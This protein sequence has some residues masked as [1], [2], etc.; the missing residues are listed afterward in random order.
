MTNTPLFS[1]LIANFNNGKFFKDCYDSIIAQSYQ[2]W[3]AIIVDDCST[4]NSVQLIRQL[5]GEDKRFKLYH[6][7]ENK[8]CGFTKRRCVELASGEICGFLDPDDIITENALEVT[9]S[10]HINNPETS[11]VYSDFAFCDEKLTEKSVRN[12]KQIDNEDKDFF[13]LTGVI[14]HFTAFKKSYYSKTD[15]INS[16]LK[17]AVDQDLYL[18]L[19]E[20]GKVLHIN[21][22]LYK[23]RIHNDGIST[24][25]NAAKAHFWHWV[26]IIDAAK[27]RGVNVEELFISRTLI[28]QMEKDLENE[29]A[30]YNK[31]I[32]FK[33]LRKLGLFKL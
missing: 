1:I 33:F 20:Q 23:Y 4:D 31:S 7:E 14:S 28:P 27:R 21:K 17:R 12:Q 11:L 2:N 26:V 6:N 16:F 3:E 8:G 22:K 13:N 24:N 10:V 30:S 32:V 25:A 18:K 9:V 29:I 15:G 5:I 19:Y